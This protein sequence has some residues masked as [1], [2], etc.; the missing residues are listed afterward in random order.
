ML[1]T[2]FHLLALNFTRLPECPPRMDFTLLPILALTLTL[3]RDGGFLGPGARLVE[4]PL[5][6]D[7]LFFDGR[8]IGVISSRKGFELST[9]SLETLFQLCNLTDRADALPSAWRR[10]FL[11]GAR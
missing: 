9:Q 5:H 2:A 3:M 11:F 4:G 7:D 6:P 8:R 1:Q 10:T